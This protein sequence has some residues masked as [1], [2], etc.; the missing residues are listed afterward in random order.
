[1][2]TSCTMLLITLLAAAASPAFAVDS[3]TSTDAPDLGSVRSAIEARDYQRSIA[4]LEAMIDHG[5]QHADV[6]NLLGYSLRKSGDTKRA[7]TFYRKALDFD[8]NH[9]GALEYLGELYVEIGDLTNARANEA[10]LAAL[11]PQGCDELED[12]RQ[13]IA[14]AT[15]TSDARSATAF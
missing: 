8:P 9:K 4:E 10:R 1:M 3:A 2:K 12:L 6:Y 5:V 15:S 14:H 7:L 13:A 11:C